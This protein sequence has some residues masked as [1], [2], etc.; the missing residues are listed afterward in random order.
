MASVEL[1]KSSATITFGA[2]SDLGRVRSENQDS[3]GKFPDDSDDITSAKGQLFIVADGMG[4]QKGGREASSI[5]LNTIKQQYFT[6]PDTDIAKSLLRALQQANEAV[7]QYSTTHVGFTNMGT[8]CSALVLKDNRAYIAHVGDSRV[9]RITKGGIVQVTD[10]HSNVAEMQR[11][12]LLTK[13]EAKNHT[14]RSYLYRAIGVRPEVPID[15]IEPIQ[16]STAETFLL[17]SDGLVNHVEDDEIM[18]ILKTHSPKEACEELVA[19]AN[20]R[21][22]YDNITVL[23]AHAKYTDSFLGRLFG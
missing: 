8:T 11:R 14:E 2:C 13:E 9:Y 15:M 20:D 18:R 7:Y 19:M 5:A 21:G 4:G 12:G 23:V 10:D 1:M 3:Y 16:L 6:D 22:G 17:C